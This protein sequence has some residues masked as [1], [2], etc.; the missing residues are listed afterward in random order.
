MNRYRSVL[1]SIKIIVFF[2][3][4]LVSLLASDIQT[5]C[6][7]GPRPGPQKISHRHHHTFRKILAERHTTKVY[8]KITYCI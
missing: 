1:T 6:I 4:T 2:R 8:N 5:A 3:L 7:D